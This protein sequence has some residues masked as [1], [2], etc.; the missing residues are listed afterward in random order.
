MS[1]TDNVINIALLGTANQE[2]T[3]G[4]L[5]EDLAGT[6]ERVKASTADG[7]GSLLQGGCGLFRLLPFGFGA[8]EIKKILFGFQRLGRKCGLMS[9]R[10]R[11][12]Y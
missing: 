3:S 10:K 5:P 1:I 12:R 9:V 2:M 7:G 11:L 4:E 6:L 8:F